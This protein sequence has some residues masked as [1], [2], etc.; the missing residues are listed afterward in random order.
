MHADYRS[1][2]SHYN[3]DKL[4]YKKRGGADGR[5]GAR[6]QQVEGYPQLIFGKVSSIVQRGKIE[7]FFMR[8]DNNFTASNSSF[9]TIFL[10]SLNK[11]NPA[12]FFVL[13]G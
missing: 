11:P 13:G 12:I 10:F 9:R 8:R 4:I 2:P 3:C 1:A 7:H 5:S 6:T